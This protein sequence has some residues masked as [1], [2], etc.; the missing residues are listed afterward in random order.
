MT[1][2]VDWNNAFIGLAVLP[3]L[4]NTASGP[5]ELDSGWALPVFGL[6]GVGRR[7]TLAEPSNFSASAATWCVY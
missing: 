6:E 4:S 7:N 1:R 3:G 2:R 5:E